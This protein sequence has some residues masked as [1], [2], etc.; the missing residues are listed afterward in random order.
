M[1]ALALRSPAYRGEPRLDA[2]EI[3]KDI[4]IFGG[5][6]SGFV[7]LCKLRWD[8]QDR[9][10]KA[11]EAEA[12]AADERRAAEAAKEANRNEL[13]QIATEAAGRVIS[14]LSREELQTFAALF[15]K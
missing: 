1:S 15:Q 3:I 5:G 10:R 8:A 13:V 14:D 2:I 6:L 7:A 11:R 4:A 9:L 12:A